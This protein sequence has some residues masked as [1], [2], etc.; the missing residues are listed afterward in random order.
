[1]LKHIRENG[2]KVLPKRGREARKEQKELTVVEVE[3]AAN[4]TAE[5]GVGRE[6]SRLELRVELTSDKEGMNFRG[7]LNHFNKITRFINA[8]DV[9]TLF[10]QL[11]AVVV[12][13][14]IPVSMAF[15]DFLGA[16]QRLRQ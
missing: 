16:V 8:R 2:G 3:C 9:Q 7:K 14:L 11:V 5:Q 4:E 12:I 6:R 10:N 1:M 15:T 13:D